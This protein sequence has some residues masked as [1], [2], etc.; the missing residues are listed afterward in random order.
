[1]RS[2]PANSAET[3]PARTLPGQ[4][5]ALM[6]DGQRSF[7]T[8]VLNLVPDSGPY[9]GTD[10]ALSAEDV[11]RV[12]ER[13]AWMGADE[14]T[15]LATLFRKWDTDESGEVEIG[16]LQGILNDVIRDLFDQIDQDGSGTLSRDE[17]RLLGRQLGQQLS[18][19]QLKE[20]FMTMKS[21]S[22]NSTESVTDGATFEE[23]L[24]WW[25]GWK[26]NQSEADLSDLLKEVDSDDS[27]GVDIHEFISIIAIKMEGRHE[28][29][30]Q[31]SSMQM[32][33]MALESVRDDVRAIYGSDSRP[34]TWLQMQ[35]EQEEELQRRCCLLRPDEVGGGQ[36][37]CS[38]R[39]KRF[40][41]VAQILL[42]GYV[43][44]A[45]PY[46]WGFGIHVPSGSFWF[47][48]EIIVDLYF[49]SDIVVNFRTAYVDDEAG[50]QIIQ[51]PKM[52]AVQYCKG[53]F[54]IDILA[55]KYFGV[56]VFSLLSFILV[57][58]VCYL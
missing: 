55:C 36:A 27:G 9:H 25:Q 11:R 21:H 1:M 30:R 29:G 8:R 39:F 37:S 44:I 15:D 16:E 33:R 10:A 18:H 42:L 34:K 23:F 32:V 24:H 54:S 19:Q 17:V 46:R 20:A 4:P 5:N 51:N 13:Y 40:W 35:A 49:V 12:C 2:T 38:V 14:V 41:D 56:Q 31:Y 57:S 43:A 7:D 53:W 28:Q 50:G 26:G 3:E 22:S 48:F 52:I 6:H 45:V 47:L 58:F